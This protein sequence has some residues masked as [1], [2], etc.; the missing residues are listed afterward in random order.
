MHIRHFLPVYACISFTWKSF[1]ILS[2]WSPSALLLG[3]LLIVTPATRYF[4]PL[5]RLV[6]AEVKAQRVERYVPNEHRYCAATCHF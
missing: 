2:C 3:E 1:L 5:E 6:V 4:L